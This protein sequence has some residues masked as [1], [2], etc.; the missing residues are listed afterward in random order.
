MFNT[1]Y[2]NVERAD[3]LRAKVETQKDNLLLD[4]GTLE[5]VS[6]DLRFLLNLGDLSGTG[7]VAITKLILGNQSALE[8]YRGLVEGLE[9]INDKQSEITS[10]LG[11]VIE[12][13]RHNV[14]K[15]RQKDVGKL[16]RTKESEIQLAKKRI[17]DQ[18]SSLQL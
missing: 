15:Q 6:Y 18:S 14:K 16:E 9:S 2:D 4:K 7:A 5:G 8:R 17:K 11:T 1:Y 12:K 3:G 10:G 13:T